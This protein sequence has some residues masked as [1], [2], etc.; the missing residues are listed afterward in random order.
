[1]FIQYIV[2][3]GVQFSMWPQGGSAVVPTCPVLMTS[4]QTALA[5]WH[6]SRAFCGVLKSVLT[7]A[8]WREVEAL[9]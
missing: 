4:T 8:H 5:L 9:R 3:A 2:G 7:A 1:M 6:L